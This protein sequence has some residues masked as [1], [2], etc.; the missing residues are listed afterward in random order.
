MVETDSEDSDYALLG[1]PMSDDDV[2]KSRSCKS[3]ALRASDADKL[4]RYQHPHRQEVYDDQGRRRFHG[5]FTGG[6]AAGYFNTVGSQEGWAPSQWKS[7][8][9]SRNDQ[10]SRQKPED[11]MD[12][13]DLA[14]MRTNDLL[15]A[16]EG[17]RKRTSD[18]M[19]AAKL[20]P[21]DCDTISTLHGCDGDGQ[22]GAEPLSASSFSFARLLLIPDG[23]DSIGHRM[24]RQMGWRDGFGI[25]ARIYRPRRQQ[26]VK[27]STS[28]STTRIR[29][30][31]YLASN[32]E[33][34]DDQDA[35]ESHLLSLSQSRGFAP[36][37]VALISSAYSHKN[38]LFGVGYEPH[39]DAPEFKAMSRRHTSQPKAT[40]S[41]G[42]R[43][44]YDDIDDY[45]ATA[46]M[47]QYDTAI[48]GSDLTNSNLGD[49]RAGVI[50][51]ETTRDRAAA[52]GDRTNSRSSLVN[53]FVCAKRAPV[54]NAK[55]NTPKVPASYQEHHVFPEGKPTELSNA[56]AEVLQLV[57]RRKTA[58][59][60]SCTE[61]PLP[62]GGSAGVMVPQSVWSLV[63]KGEMVNLWKRIQT[64][65]AYKNRTTRPSDP[66][67]LPSEQQVS[68]HAV[69]YTGAQTPNP[70]AT[71]PSPL[72]RAP[73]A[74]A[75]P[76]GCAQSSEHLI[77]P[78]GGYSVPDTCRPYRNDPAKQQRFEAFLRDDT[79]VRALALQDRL[80]DGEFHAEMNEFARVAA[81]FSQQV[82]S[83]ISSRFTSSEVQGVQLPGGI[84]AGGLCRPSAKIE[85]TT[86]GQNSSTKS[87]LGGD[88]STGERAT[89]KAPTLLVG[90]SNRAEVPWQPDALLCKRFGLAAPSNAL[91]MR[92]GAALIPAGSATFDDALLPQPS[93]PQHRTDLQND[94]ITQFNTLSAREQAS[95]FLASLTPAHSQMHGQERS[96]DVH[97]G[98]AYDAA[99]RVQAPSCLHPQM[100]P[101]T[102]LAIPPP[103][104][105]V[106][107]PSIPSHQP[108]Q[109]EHEV[110]EADARLSRRPPMALF[111]AV[112]AESS[113]D[114]DY[115]VQSTVSTASTECTNGT[116]VSSQAAPGC[117]AANDIERLARNGDAVRGDVSNPEHADGVDQGSDGDSD[118]SDAQQRKRK[119][120]KHHNKDSS[121]RHHKKKRHHRTRS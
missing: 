88:S 27:T 80:D 82:H 98:S 46:D 6:F 55:C 64:I 53:G 76:R 104:P 35:D 120:H 14:D 78:M 29:A 86:S 37:P 103:P 121:Q 60:S 97:T 42:V 58:L 30:E 3:K 71:F 17:F 114:E 74:H 115:P 15:V 83:V 19:H 110:L 38:D 2:D 48:D 8:R 106:P 12:D 47:S 101:S 69:Q 85:S 116:A 61:A 23:A 36:A 63:S 100:P 7:S 28:S 18:P 1:T 109:S 31:H 84:S 70:S 32:E 44:I 117:A 52:H 118:A 102:R 45:Y 93:V 77:R 40:A 11:F 34:I 57:E 51:L 113:D 4:T 56:A 13:E 21:K 89:Q 81:F 96:F 66:A 73:D 43:S 49:V 50:S 112:F 107:P 25:G 95:N 22:G 105:K 16:R 62:S 91:R 39:R 24:L 65:Q 54:T 79:T 33:E 72:D 99:G 9:G 119:R 67:A 87:Q 26:R 59:T 108:E 111:K 92:Q 20:P 5:A 10:S 90:K 75:K 94:T 68:A 41:L